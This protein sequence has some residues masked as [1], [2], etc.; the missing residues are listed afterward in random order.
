MKIS[1]SDYFDLQTD[2]C[3]QLVTY[4][5]YGFL[6]PY[7][8]KTCRSSFCS[9]Q[10]FWIFL[11]FLKLKIRAFQES[12][13]GISLRIKNLEMQTYKFIR[14]LFLYVAE[15]HIYLAVHVNILFR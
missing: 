13:R 1:H 12:F 5:I 7:N 3:A 8:N 6:D 15:V 9:F 14:E 11:S 4:A 2:I 10:F